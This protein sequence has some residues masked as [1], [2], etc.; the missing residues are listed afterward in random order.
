MGAVKQFMQ[1][2]Y[3]QAV[4]AG[5][6]GEVPIGAVLVAADGE[7]LARAGNQT[8][9]LSDPAAHAE[10]LVLR[11][12]AQ[13]LANYRLAGTTLYVTLE[14]CVMCMGALI[15]ARVS[16]LV[17]AA[18]DPKAGAVESR[19]QLGTDGKLNHTLTYESGPMTEPCAKLL[20]DFFR[21]RRGKQAQTCKV[22]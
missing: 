11:A 8:I 12:A 16:H 7:I 3:E 20:R 17:F 4:M 19:Y 22:L 15:H 5:A 21:Q 2:A 6:R 18:H 1:L 10:V 14:P 9:D 13:K